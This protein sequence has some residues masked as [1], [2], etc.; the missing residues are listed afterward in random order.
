MENTIMSIAEKN[1]EL[2]RRGYEAFNTADM[3]TLTELFHENAVWH[4]P[5]QGSIAGSRKGR[6]AVFTQFGRY[7]AETAGTFRAELKDIAMCEDGLIVGIHRNTGERN[8]RK[9]DVD[10][11][12][13]FRII[14][15]QLIEG[16]EYFF[17]L[18]AWDTFW[19]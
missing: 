9:L 3:K 19:S 18:K 7:G 10:C 8:G 13:V 11:C 1:A 16:R 5:G 17:D 12:I 2:V 14:D 4:T 15:D 6:N